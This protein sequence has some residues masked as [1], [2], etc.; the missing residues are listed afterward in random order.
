MPEPN[1]HITD[2]GKSFGHV[3]LKM[4]ERNP[5]GVPIP[6]RRGEGHITKYKNKLFSDQ[7]TEII[8]FFI[9]F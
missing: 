7:N 1:P 2:I 3:F 8:N 6:V 9:A 5:R 4:K